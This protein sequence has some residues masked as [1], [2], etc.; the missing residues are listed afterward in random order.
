MSFID[1]VQ[2][3]QQKGNIN[4]ALK[5]TLNNFYLSYQK[6][7]THLTEEIERN[8]DFFLTEVLKEL[9][10]PYRFE[11]FHQAIRT[12]RDYYQFGL[13]FMRPLV[14]FKRSKI[15]HSPLLH[16][17]EAQLKQGDNI[18]FLANH[19]TEPDPQ[20]I[21]LL[22]EK[23]HPNLAENMIFVAGHRVITDPLAIPF[24]KGRNLL[25]I[26]S[27]RYLDQAEDKVEKIA[28]NQKTM[29]IM[30]Q[31]LEEGGKCIYVAPSGG[32]DRPNALGQIEVAP[33][34]AASLEMFWLMSQKSSKNTHFYPLAL[35]TYTLLPPPNSVQREIGESRNTQRA[36][37]FLNFCPPFDMENFPGSE[38]LDKKE[39]RKA[40]AEQIWK[41]VFS[42]YKE[43]EKH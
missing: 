25:C 40:R 1:K 8:L 13:D 18:I 26:Y 42:A 27:K 37:I 12:P 32:R 15:L 9:K 33:F 22:L 5:E 19:Q 30:S 36:P 34:D 3:E 14:E 7:I 35:H 10:S 39:K 21:S 11:P 4:P 24:S 23:E 43:L 2:M 6:A 29:K 20:L 38:N 28:H 17:I 31:L 41:I 16:H